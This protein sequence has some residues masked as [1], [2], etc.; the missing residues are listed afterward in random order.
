VNPAAPDFFSAQLFDA[1]K[2][3]AKPDGIAR[4]EWQADGRVKFVSQ[5]QG[6]YQEKMLKSFTAGFPAGT[7]PPGVNRTDIYAAAGEAGWGMSFNQ[8]NATG[9]AALYAYDETG[10]PLWLTLVCPMTGNTCEGNL[11][12]V[13][14]PAYQEAYDPAK[15]RVSTYGT[16]RIEWTNNDR[17]TLTTTVNGRTI[18]KTIDRLAF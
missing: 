2:A 11:N 4:F 14:G 8:K 17:A 10:K 12:R 9:F 6:R 15:V 13:T 5:F 18:S 1:S 7:A 3:K 16:A